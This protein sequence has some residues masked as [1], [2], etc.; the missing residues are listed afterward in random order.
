MEVIDLEGKV[1]CVPLSKQPLIK[2]DYK[3]RLNI[4][5]YFKGVCFVELLIDNNVN[6]KKILIE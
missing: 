1:I 5:K 3:Y 6:I 4:P 2:G